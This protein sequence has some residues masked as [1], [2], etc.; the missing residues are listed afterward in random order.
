MGG[1]GIPSPS[2][3]RSLWFEQSCHV[4]GNVMRSIKSRSFDPGSREPGIPQFGVPE[5]SVPEMGALE[6]GSSRY[7]S[8]EDRISRHRATQ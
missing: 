8:V 4:R 5:I 2:G 1:T 3:T 6:H 7:G